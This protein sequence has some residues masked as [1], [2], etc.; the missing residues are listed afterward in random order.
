MTGPRSPL[1]RLMASRIR[2]VAA[3]CSMASASC[4]SS[5]GCEA[6]RALDRG[7]AARAP[8]PFVFPGVGRRAIE[9]SLPGGSKELPARRR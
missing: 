7:T 6:E 4:R 9:L 3:C 2:A 1:A 5:S 8:F